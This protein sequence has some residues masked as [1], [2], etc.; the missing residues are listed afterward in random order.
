M[1][2]Q[3][4]FKSYLNLVVFSAAVDRKWLLI[5]FFSEELK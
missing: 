3:G 4:E 5:E 2:T 1:K